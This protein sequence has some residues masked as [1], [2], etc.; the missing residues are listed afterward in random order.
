MPNIVNNYSSTIITIYQD[1]IKTYENN[2]KTIKEIE[3]EMN[4][5]NH[6]IEL[7][8]QKEIYKGYLI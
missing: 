7:S 1:V 3:E 6:E 2:Q 5:V 8:D 4:D